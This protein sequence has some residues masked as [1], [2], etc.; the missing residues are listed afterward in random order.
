M[1]MALS[2]PLPLNGPAQAHCDVWLVALDRAVPQA[3]RAQLSTSERERSQ[4]FVF[5][6]DRHRFVAAHA[7][8]RQLLAQRTGLPG[9]LVE[10]TENVFGKPLLAGA[11]PG[12]P[13]APHF[14]LSHSQG[15]GAVALSDTHE[16]GIDV[17]VLRPLSD[18]AAM[19]RTYFTPAEQRA[20][21]RVESRGA[22]AAEK[23]FFTCWTRKEACL[24]ALGLGLQLATDSFEVGVEA[25]MAEALDIDIQ[26]LEGIERVRLESF[27]CGPDAVGALALRLARDT[28]PSVSACGAA[29]ASKTSA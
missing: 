27:P 12:G 5:A 16:I 7:A 2:M 21:E 15:L 29:H 10:L 3:L 26:T 11:G 25:N 23:A 14:N 6:R 4:R 17:E 1:T 24:K 19:A 20:L 18:R 9:A 28:S 13:N 22:L 8:L